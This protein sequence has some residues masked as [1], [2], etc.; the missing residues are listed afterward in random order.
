MRAISKRLSSL[1]LLAATAVAQQSAAPAPQPIGFDSNT[2][3][4]DAALPVLRKHFAFAGY[5]LTNP[6]R[7]NSNSWLGKGDALLKQGFGFLVLANGKDDDVILKA[8]KTSKVSA[9]AVGRRDAEAVVI[10]AKQEH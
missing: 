3:P 8:M 7:A 9:E 10:T 2:Y 5:W 1:V 4:G 6:P